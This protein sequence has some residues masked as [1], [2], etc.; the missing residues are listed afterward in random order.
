MSLFDAANGLLF[1]G[2]TYY[3]GTIWLYR[4]ETDLAAYGKS[5]H[6]LAALAPR[7]KVVSGAHNVPVARPEVLTELAAAFDEVR[8]KS[9]APSPAGEGKVEYK[10]GEISFLMRDPTAHERRGSGVKN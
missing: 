5:V 7:V 3:P 4:P 10:V 8:A 2:D 6:R 9:V 1:T